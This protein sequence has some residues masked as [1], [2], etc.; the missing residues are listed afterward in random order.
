MSIE[1]TSWDIELLTKVQSSC[2]AVMIDGAWKRK[3]LLKAPELFQVQNE[4]LCFR[5]VFDMGLLA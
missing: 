4:W 1:G 3:I 5:I 2:D